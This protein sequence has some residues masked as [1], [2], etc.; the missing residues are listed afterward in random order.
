MNVLHIFLIDGDTQR[1]VITKDTTPIFKVFQD[2]FVRLGF[3]RPNDDVFPATQRCTLKLNGHLTI[4]RH[5]L[6]STLREL[7]VNDGDFI[8]V[9]H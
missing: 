1:G 3:L 9:I 8:A 2:H 7:N 5:K 4:P 6:Y